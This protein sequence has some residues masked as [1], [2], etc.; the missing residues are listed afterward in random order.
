MR[1][2]LDWV[3]PSDNQRYDYT[4]GRRDDE[5]FPDALAA[6]AEYKRELG[7][8]EPEPV[9]P[10]T[11]AMRR[12][13]WSVLF[14]QNVPVR[15]ADALMWHAPRLFY[16]RLKKNPR[17]PQSTA[18]GIVT[19]L[20]EAAGGVLPPAAMGLN[21]HKLGEAI[22]KKREARR[23]KNSAP[24]TPAPIADRF[25][26]MIR[27]DLKT[28]IKDAKFRYPK[29]DDVDYS[30]ALRKT[31]YVDFPV[32]QIDQRKRSGRRGKYTE[33]TCTVS[34][35]WH[36]K[37]F[38]AGLANIFGPRTLVLRANVV[39][40]EGTRLTVATQGKGAYKVKIV[41]GWLSRGPN[42]EPVLKLI[43]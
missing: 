17:Y 26:T 23:G 34:R 21:V 36:R 28:A 14:S 10:E 6:I 16:E 18:Y 5:L 29:P 20:N 37:V 4:G 42:H 1:F 9:D 3:K 2:K 12:E 38:R 19:A 39:R 7:V 25:D 24:R 13:Q 22:E 41:D 31:I 43:Y 40:N 30:L 11:L 15:E 8:P 32:F 35:D 27:G 33:I